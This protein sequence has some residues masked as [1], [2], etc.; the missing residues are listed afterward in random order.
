MRVLHV[1]PSVSPRHGGPSYAIKAYARALLAAGIE[2]TIAT[3]DDDGTGQL[4]LPLGVAVEN[5]GIPHIF[6]RRNLRPY[7]VSLGLARWLGSR[8]KDFD[9]LHLHAVFSFSSTVAARAA[10]R[11]RI[12]YVVRPLGVLNRWGLENRRQALKQISLRAVEL[13]MLRRAAALHFTAR[14]E[15]DEALLVS[16]ELQEIRRAIIPVPVEGT[17]MGEATAFYRRFPIARGRKVVLFL[18]RVDE[19]KGVDLL[20]D[21]F[22]IAQ[23]RDSSLL[24]V[25]AGAGQASYQ[26][27]LEGQARAQG[28]TESILWTGYLGGNDKAGAFAAASVFVLPSH[29]ENFGIA[30]VEAMAAG[31]PIVISKEVAISADVSTYEAGL[32][33]S[34]KTE[35]IAQAL[36]RTLREPEATAM[37]LENGKRLVREKY[38]PAAVGESLKDLYRTILG[39]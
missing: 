1:I 24:L 20:I 11:Q 18:S 12:P 3:T 2:V 27:A 33:V 16:N 30:P 37:R 7:K 38:S 4:K 10:R 22:R 39:E 5:N 8:A 29:S 19:K 26:R 21:A 14:A 6:F 23:T 28:I 13:P 25:V 17:A 34:R 35:A 36:L 31:V 15:A 32:I 9:L